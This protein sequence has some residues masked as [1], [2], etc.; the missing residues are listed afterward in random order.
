[1]P[2]RD[3]SDA[4][5]NGEPTVKDLMTSNVFTLYEDDNL[6]ILKELMNWRNIRHVPVIDQDNRLV[7]LMTH[8]DFLKIALSKLSEISDSDADQVYEDIPIGQVMTR[9]VIVID[10]DTP[11][12]EAAEVLTSSKFGC[13]PVVNEDKL[14]GIITEADFVRAFRDWNITFNALVG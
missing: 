7:G 9:D 5:V 14:L 8:R 3:D 4:L 2:N 10:A 1:M 13:L 6:R 12:S 11:L